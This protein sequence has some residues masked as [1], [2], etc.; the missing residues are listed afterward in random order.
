MANMSTI[1]E[2]LN[3]ALTTFCYLKEIKKVD[4]TTILA[5][6]FKGTHSLRIFI[7]RRMVNSCNTSNRDIPVF[8]I[9]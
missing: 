8:K 3:G 6:D 4:E 2:E 9:F 7:F 5:K 1:T